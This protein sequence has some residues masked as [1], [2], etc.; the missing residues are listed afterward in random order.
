VQSVSL[1]TELGRHVVHRPTDREDVSRWSRARCPWSSR[2]Y[3]EPPSATR[4]PP[5]A[6]AAGVH[7]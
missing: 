2:R 1:E 5:T 4:R 6:F 3:A 7:S